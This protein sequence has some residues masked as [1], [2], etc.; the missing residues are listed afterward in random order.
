MPKAVV[1][2]HTVSSLIHPCC[3][4]YIRTCPPYIHS[5][6]LAHSHPLVHSHPLIQS[7][8]FIHSS[9]LIRSP[10]LIHSSTLIRSSSRPL[11]STHP[12]SSVQPLSSTRPPRHGG[13][14]LC[15]STVEYVRPGWA[16]TV[17]GEWVAVV[18]TR[19]FAQ[20]VRV[21]LCK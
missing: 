4:G 3:N 18:N 8:T 2:P 16:E 19:A 9:T 14:F 15:E 7:P 10:T 11:S 6:P 5:Y 1:H 17:G 12:S 21:E 20:R 13:Q